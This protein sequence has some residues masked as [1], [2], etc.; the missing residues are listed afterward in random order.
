MIIGNIRKQIGKEPN[1]GKETDT[2]LNA[3]VE[4]W[5]ETPDKNKE[6]FLHFRDCLS[7]KEG[8]ELEFIS[9]PGVTH[10]LRAAHA[11]QKKRGL[12]VMVDVIEDEPRW[13]SVCFY[14][15]MI[16]DPEEKGDFV[17]Q[18]LLGEDAVCFD[19]EERDEALIRY[20]ELRL[21]EAHRSASA[22]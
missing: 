17:P 11:G 13:L 3:F 8:V 21:D 10:S 12:F 15:E 4:Q 16:T 14:G 9:R 1:M 5:R 20:I 6:T 18:G 7:A 22:K 2:E 19:I